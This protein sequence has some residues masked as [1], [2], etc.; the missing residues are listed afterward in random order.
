M[1]PPDGGSLIAYLESLQKVRD[2]GPAL[3]C[4][5]HGPWITDPEPRIAGYIEHRLGRERRLL[6][7]LDRGVTSRSAL[8][9]E[10][11]DDAPE[12]LR[13]FAALTMQAHLEKLAME[14]RLPLGLGDLSS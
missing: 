7:A 8:L 5:G 3:I 11:W 4:P 9:D 12:V 1:V 2:L 6:A 10:V 13:D 14:D